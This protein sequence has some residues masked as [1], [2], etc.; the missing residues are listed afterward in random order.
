MECAL[1]DNLTLPRLRCFKQFLLQHIKENC[2]STH[3][4][5][6]VLMIEADVT[7]T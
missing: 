4:S 6:H 2:H 3:Y 5:S 1:D 7:K